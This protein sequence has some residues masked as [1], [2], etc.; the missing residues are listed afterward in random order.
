MNADR[1]GLWTVL[2]PTVPD[3]WGNARMLCVCVCGQRRP[4]KVRALETG[5]SLGCQS[6]GCRNRA[7]AAGAIERSDAAGEPLS[8]TVCSRQTDGGPRCAECTAESTSAAAVDGTTPYAED[9]AAQY[10]V[11]R[12][13]GGAPH[14]AIAMAM[15]ITRERVR[16]IE[17]V[18]LRNLRKRLALVG[19][20]GEEDS[21][22][23]HARHAL[24]GEG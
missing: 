2:R 16:Q 11:E 19:I 12:F 8:C 24:A 13:P 22:F 23:A 7:Q 20:R 21:R 15:G 6:K 1:V 3:S 10:F 17:A 14:T 4:V 5:R 18:A 9:R